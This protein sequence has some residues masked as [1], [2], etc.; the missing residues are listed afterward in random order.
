M[1]VLLGWSI[2]Q[3]LRQTVLHGYVP[4]KDERALTALLIIRDMRAQLQRQL[5]PEIRGRNK[6]FPLT[7][8]AIGAAIEQ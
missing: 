7:H 1:Y 3:G 2:E 6:G 5:E 8:L 4:W